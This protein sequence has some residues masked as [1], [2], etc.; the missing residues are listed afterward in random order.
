MAKK[1]KQYDYDLAEVKRLIGETDKNYREIAQETGCPY[2]SVVYHGRKI[3]GR[4]NR[5]R[6][7]EMNAELNQAP[8]FTIKEEP[9]ENTNLLSGGTALSISRNDIH[10]QDAEQEAAKMIKAARALGLTKIN[11]TIDR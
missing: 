9:K 6:Q 1:S 7:E 2:A 3:R 5:I 4:V 11:I 10:I 8:V